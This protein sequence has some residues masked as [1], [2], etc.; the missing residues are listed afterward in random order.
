MTRNDEELIVRWGDELVGVVSSKDG[1]RALSFRYDEHATR[2]VSL[3]MPRT[4][5]EEDGAFFSNLLPEAG[6][7]TRL[8]QSLGVS[9]ENTFALLK[10]I[11]GDCA[12]A[13]TLLPHNKPP[14][15]AAGSLI[16][17]ER[18]LLTSMRIDGALSVLVEEGLRLSLAGA[19]EK[20]AV[21]VED[22]KL[23][24]PQG[25]RASTHIL[26]F[27][28]LRFRGLVENEFFIMRLA[29]A[30]G[31]P[32]A[33]VKAWRI[34]DDE[35]ALLVERFDRKEGKRLHQE[36]F[37]QA[38][39][40]PEHLKYEGEGGPSF[41]DI[42]NLVRRHSERPAADIEELIRWQAFNVLVGNNDGHAKNV[43]FLHE[44]QRRLAPAYDLL[45]TRAWPLLSKTI[46]MR[47]GDA[48]LAGDVSVRNWHKEAERCH[49][50]KSFVTE[51]VDELREHITIAAPQTAAEVSEELGAATHVMKVLAQVERHCRWQAR[52]ARDWRR[53][54]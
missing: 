6:E 25:A 21:V 16:P 24:L 11:G 31:L 34:F 33:P 48:R 17:L 41:A 13:L 40:L 26:K 3:S 5:D 52:H 14:S 50:G 30:V 44:P 39:G 9:A 45:C 15:K 29:A 2:D 46:A 47:I 38:V 28:S 1:G 35:H 27:A 43:S 36:D 19:Q 32:V 7:R 8:A 49:L 10:A 54:R 12:G 20:V 51:L 4:A 53:S 37:C 42:V 23:F 18:R 22:G